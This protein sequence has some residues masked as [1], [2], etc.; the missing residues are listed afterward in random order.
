MIAAASVSAKIHAAEQKAESDRAVA[1]VSGQAGSRHLPSHSRT[2]L[3]VSEWYLARHPPA[4]PFLCR[5]RIG[6]VLSRAVQCCF[7]ACRNTDGG[8]P[9]Q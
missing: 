8:E 7:A 9:L 4:G 3:S 6:A 2:S 1:V 5:H